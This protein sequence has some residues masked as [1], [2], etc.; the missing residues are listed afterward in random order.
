MKKVRYLFV[1]LTIIL[2][3][4]IGNNT[5]ASDDSDSK[6]LLYQDATINADGS[7]TVK[8][9]LWLNGSYNGAERE[10]KFSDYS[11]YPFTGIYSNFSGDTDIY[12]ATEVTDIKVYDISQSKFSSIDDINNIEKKFKEV[13]SAS[14][15]K[16]GVYTITNS[17]YKSTVA[18]YCPSRKKKVFYLEYTIKD[19]VVVHNDI[20]ELYWCFLENNSSETIL[21]YKLRVH[22]PQ[23]DSN[24]MV[25]SHGPATGECSIVDS[26][27]L[28]LTDSNIAPY[29]FETIRIM[30][31]K[32]LVPQAEKKSNVDGKDYIIKYENAMADS[33]I[34]SSETQKIDIENQLSQAFIQ[35]DEDPSIYWY[36]KANKL[37]EKYTWDDI[38]KQEYQENLNEMKEA[39]NQS[40]KE[41]VEWEYNYIIKYNQIS[42]SKINYLIRK[43]DDG[44]DEDAKSQYYAMA[45]E[46]QNQLTEK[47]LDT[48]QNIVKIVAIIYCI[49]GIICILNL[50]K[51][52]FERNT[53]HEKYYR[54]FP[55]DDNAYIIDYLINKKIT[56]KTF[57]VTLLDLIAKKRIRIEK[58]LNDENN[59]D[60]VLEE[61]LFARSMSENAVIEMLF[62]LVG[63]NNRCS[64]K[65][66]KN[67]GKAKD[68]SYY[69]IEYLKKFDKGI[70]KEIEKKEY[71]KKDNKFIQLFIKLPI[72]L[73]IICYVLGFCISQ[74]GY[75][76]TTNYY[77]VITV[78]SILYYMILSSDKR[79]TKKGKLEYSKWLAH[80]RFLKDF[81]SFD[82]KELPEIIL[83]DRYLVTATVLNCSD[84]VLK[85]MKIYVNSYEGMEN[86]QGII[87]DYMSYTSIRDLD[88]E[89]NTLMYRSRINTT[90]S[91]S[92]SSYSSGSGSG[93]GSS[94]GGSGGGGGGWSRF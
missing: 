55:S 65:E 94:D 1:F 68:N 93:G 48:K 29:K 78:L 36:N 46:L 6:K 43:I 64:L 3:I 61:G 9:A 10:I 73:G 80:K 27:T 91:S 34:S 83:W 12:N 30:F 25:W 31:D 54:D 79:R 16:Y 18:I 62:K 33:T 63:S 82:Q 24:V 77:I 39:V 2:A 17:N 52:A 51:R 90:D 15:G 40:W 88:H 86:M 66:L 44:F 53:F 59:F 23:E 56:A 42:Q 32:S 35:L 41:S 20:A 22:L 38:Q 69:I 70:E 87:H 37:L 28:S 7:I 72:I 8:E 76:S 75:I 60:F 26:E 13:E 14:K 57:S 19:A 67:F 47:K 4:C 89:I 81:G 50:I 11:S 58:T 71:F 45:N 21:D 5:Y 92:G 84:K 85:Q 74:N 49:L